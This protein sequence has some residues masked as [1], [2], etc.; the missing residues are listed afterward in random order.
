MLVVDD[1]A[2][3]RETTVS[4]LR[5]LNICAAEAETGA[6]AI[7]AIRDRQFDLAL[8]DF[9]LPDI[10]G[11]DVVVELKKA[12][13]AV[14]WLLMSGLMTPSLAVEAMRLGA[15]DAVELPFDVEKVVVS[16][17]YATSTGEPGG[18]P[19]LPSPSRLTR[20]RSAAE[21]WAYLV[22]RACESDHDLKTIGEWASVAGISYS[23]LTECCRLVGIRP[24]DARDFLRML[25][26]LAHAGGRLENLEHG[27][28]VNDHRTLKTLFDRA[29]LPLDGGTGT[30]SLRAFVDRQQ[31]VDRD[32]EAVRW[33][34]KAIGE[35]R[36]SLDKRPV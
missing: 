2:R 11:L 20:P 33:L 14:P 22:L 13:I 3:T 8:I 23:A 26:A 6:E 9:R 4:V 29:S 19:P 5:S 30:I 28:D 31:F 32:C 12:R 36:E 25:R 15:V 24:Y 18:W 10:S 1:D 16:A 35:V 34:L 27:L 21:R 7:A 17:L